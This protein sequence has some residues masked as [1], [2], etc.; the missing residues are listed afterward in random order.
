VRSII[1]FLKSNTS[2]IQGWVEI[3]NPTKQKMDKVLLIGNFNL[4]II[5]RG[6]IFSYIA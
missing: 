6:E 1:L 5:E 2:K 4:V 3:G